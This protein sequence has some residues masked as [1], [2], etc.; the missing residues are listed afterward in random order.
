FTKALKARL[1]DD[2]TQRVTGLA[3]ESNGPV[4]FR[5]DGSPVQLVAEPDRG[6][7]TLVNPADGRPQTRFAVPGSLYASP[8]EESFTGMTADGAVVG[9]P[10]R[11]EDGSRAL[12]VWDGTTGAL[13]H[14]F[15][16]K[17]LPVGFSP[18]GALVAGGDDEGQ[19]TLWSAA[20]G[21][22]VVSLRNSRS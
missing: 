6:A 16:G 22:E 14:T 3:A 11:K 8:S 5:P 4:G 17:F 1:W 9:A 13:G 2:R 7:L 19:V 18:D 10:I 21:Q 15:A 20:T 12:A